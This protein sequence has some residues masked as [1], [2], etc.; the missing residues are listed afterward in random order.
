MRIPVDL[1]NKDQVIT[2]H[3]EQEFENL[4]ILS[5]KISESDAYTR[6]CSD[7]G[8]VV[9]RVML[10]S[11]F[12]VQN[13]KVS[14]FIPITD[15]DA[16]RNEIT[17]LYSF[18][19]ITDTYPNGVRY[20][21]LPRIRNTKNPSHRAVGNFPD[22]SDFTHYPQYMEIMDKYYKFT[23]TT[24]QSGDYMI[25]GVPL[26]QQNIIMDFDVF[27]TDSFEIS[28][29]DLVEQSTMAQSIQ[30]LETLINSNAD[31]TN[32]NPNKVPGF[33]YQGN[34]NYEVDVKT[35]LDSMPN[36]FHEVKQLTVSPFW[37]DDN[38]CDVGI[39]RC[40]FT[41]NFKYTPTAVFFGFIQSPSGAFTI[42]P[43]YT[44]NS[45]FT[46]PV[47]SGG[48]P[49]EITA[50]DSNL[51]Q[52]S[53]DIYPF[54]KMEIVVY[55]I[56]DLSNPMRSRVGVFDGSYYNGIF[57]ISLPMY[58]EYYITNE[59]GDLV[60]TDDTT[61]GIPT[62]G[63]YSF[64]IYDTDERWTERRMATGGF[65][66]Q[67][68]PG[69]RIPCN[70]SGDP[71][72]SGWVNSGALF[73]YDVLNRQR[74]FYTVQVVHN[75][76]TLSNVL[77]AGDYVGYFP[78]FNPYKADASWNF[79]ITIDN[80]ATLDNP[81][82][83]GSIMV[84]RFLVIG[85]LGLKGSGQ[86]TYTSDGSLNRPDR[87][88]DE[89]NAD[90]LNTYGQALLDCEKYLGVG[91]QPTNGMNSGDVF[92]NLFAIDEFTWGDGNSAFGQVSTWN[93]G[94]NSQSTFT[95]SLFA[96]QLSQ[97]S[98]STAN[99]YKVQATFNQAVHTDSTFGVFLTAANTNNK[100]PL[101]SIEVYDITNDLPDLI[102]DKVYSSY[103]KGDIIRNQLNLLN[104][105]Q[106]ID[107]EPTEI[108]IE[109]DGVT[110]SDTGTVISTINDSNAYNGQFYYFGLWNEANALYDIENNYRIK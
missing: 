19:S 55:R 77:D 53:G 72:L 94:D 1:T 3:L 103:N 51:N 86:P 47:G 80:V 15:D 46:D 67:I 9:G 7:Y 89:P 31:N 58:M 44:Y 42:N 74:K 83:I 76:H 50:Y 59:F 106:V 79:P 70:S 28:A 32:I 4:E 14:I 85:D 18:N 21:L 36:I 90:Q 37:G 5:L 62:K 57:R 41:V 20:N 27:D 108:Y 105:A 8:V 69:I 92:T 82:I 68:L 73:E 91:V 40:D 107:T 23:T 39:T 35:N 97:I 75:K 84:P 81:T 48:K 95:P 98:G 49:L 99:A 96:V 45:I 30:A 12:G 88:L 17:Q 61:I 87:L 64:E 25:F 110:Y 33:I 16:D 2:V 63:Y 11:G 78:K 6:M 13:A 104:V 93:Y 102:K 43:D 65:D 109:E 22:V 24:N 71:N 66:N 10:N 29:N 54:Q 34:N 52:W 100:I 38:F 101:M 26:G 56:D 60:K